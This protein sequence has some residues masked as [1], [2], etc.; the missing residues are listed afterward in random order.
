MK[1]LA[2]AAGLVFL[3]ACRSGPHQILANR[4]R[5]TENLLVVVEAADRG[6]AQRAL[7]RRLAKQ[8]HCAAALF[9]WSWA[10]RLEKKNKT[11]NRSTP[12]LSACSKRL[13]PRRPAPFHGSQA[14]LWR[15]LRS[16]RV[17]LPAVSTYYGSND[18]EKAWAASQCNR[19]RRCA[20]ESWPPLTRVHLSAFSM[21]RTEVTVSAWNRCVKAGACSRAAKGATLRP[22]TGIDMQQAEN[23]CR[24]AGGRLPTEQEW[25]RAA[26]P[27]HQALVLWPWGNHWLGDCA[28]I[29]QPEKAGPAPVGTHPCDLSPEGLV[30]M[31]GNVAEWTRPATPER[32]RGLGLVKGGAWSDP[33]WRASIFAR[34]VVSR[35]RRDP[36]LGFRCVWPEPQKPARRN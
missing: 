2:A 11:K 13:K 25:E 22:V 36:H 7:A 15:A 9:H 19:Q 6:P 17:F 23:F 35:D 3:A 27:V 28:W 8:G 32:R 33:R 12:F 26:R 1:W 5:G 29:E 4:P 24:W 31:A 18:A 30:D 34:Q 16:A 20:I 14:R 10:N 21:S